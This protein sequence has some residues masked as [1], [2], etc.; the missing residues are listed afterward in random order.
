MDDGFSPQELV[1]TLLGSHVQPRETRRVWSGGL[2]L[3]LAELGFSD[4]A[5]RIALARL[6]HRDLLARHKEGRHVHYSLTRRTLAVLED[7]DRRIFSLGR[8]ERPSGDWTVLWQ[9]IPET[10]RRAR[11]RLV[12]RLRFLGFGSLQDGTWLAPLDREAEVLALL[13]ELDVT[14][15]AGLML[16]RPSAALDLRA[17]VTR[18]WDLDELD[19]RYR[20]FV[21]EFGSA[22]EPATDRDAFRLRTRLVHTFRE[23]PALDPELPGEL[24][25]VPGKRAAAVALFH[26]LYAALA[27]AAQR[28]FDE[29]TRV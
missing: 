10:R 14:E 27:P 15:H 22:G 18:A 5:A 7:G 25:P 12:R 16:G 23:F 8:A 3:L 24:V 29:V 26:D 17:F 6:A 11:E 20:K 28:H 2:V 4:G 13:A 1:M 19:R 21:A 9:S